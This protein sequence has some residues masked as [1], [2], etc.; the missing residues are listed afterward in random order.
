MHK[1]RLSCRDARKHG[2][3]QALQGLFDHAKACETP[4][5]VHFLSN[6]G[7]RQR[8]EIGISVLAGCEAISEANSWPAVPSMPPA[9]HA[10]RCVPI[11]NH[12]TGHLVQPREATSLSSC[13]PSLYGLR[14]LLETAT[15]QSLVHLRKTSSLHQPRILPLT[16]KS[17][18]APGS[19]E[20]IR[21]KLSIPLPCRSVMD[22][23]ASGS[24]PRLAF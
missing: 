6:T 10:A 18:T 8:P 12:A 16:Q 22:T 17:A 13:L 4:R 5:T 9:R 20:K 11:S 14:M 19:R 2:T 7:P 3:N 15:T 21:T 1:Y 23:H 24:P